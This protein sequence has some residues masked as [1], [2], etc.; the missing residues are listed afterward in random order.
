LVEQRTCNAKVEG[1]TPFSGTKIKRIQLTDTLLGHIALFATPVAKYHFDDH[2]DIKQLILG[3]MDNA[4]ASGLGVR[5]GFGN[6]DHYYNEGDLTE[7]V[8]EL[9]P[10]IDRIKNCVTQYAE[11]YYGIVGNEFIDLNVWINSTTGGVQPGHIHNNSLFSAT[12]Y[13]Q[14]DPEKH[15]GLDFLSPKN[16][17]PREPLVDVYQEVETEYNQRTV[18]LSVTE[19]DL[20][21][22]PSE[23]LHGYEQPQT[24]VPRI[25]LSMNFMPA[26]VKSHLYGFRVS[27]L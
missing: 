2:A 16:I 14:N 19:G 23:I 6:I 18:K 26:V 20:L 10:L 13:V 12:Y 21:V 5:K 24:D 25:S 15:V 1:S 17:I 22:W 3:V 9:K 4:E 11:E 7:K 8:P 27:K